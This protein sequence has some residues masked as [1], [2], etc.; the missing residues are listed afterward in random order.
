MAFPSSSTIPYMSKTISIC[1]G[2]SFSQLISK[3]H[4]VN[5]VLSWSESNLLVSDR[6]YCKAFQNNTAPSVILQQNEKLA[7]VGVGKSGLWK[8]YSCES[9]C[10]AVF[11]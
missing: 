2:Q 4:C 8:R 3:L 7:E 9:D 10:G 5:I 6:K 1:Q 11:N